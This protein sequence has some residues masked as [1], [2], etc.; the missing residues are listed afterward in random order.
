[1]AL[2]GGKEDYIKGVQFLGG[3][4]EKKLGESEGEVLRPIRKRTTEGPTASG[5]GKNPLL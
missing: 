2:E 3:R 5:K 4:S 1:M